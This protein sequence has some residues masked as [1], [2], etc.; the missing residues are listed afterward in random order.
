MHECRLVSHLP[1]ATLIPGWIDHQSCMTD[2]IN[3]CLVCNN[4][5]CDGFKCVVGNAQVPVGAEGAW[6][7]PEQEVVTFIQTHNAD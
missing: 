4:R 6:D 3:Q 5:D 7:L 1:D 2:L